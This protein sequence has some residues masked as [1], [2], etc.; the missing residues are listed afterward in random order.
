ML[1][2]RTHYLAYHLL[3]QTEAVLKYQFLKEK[4]F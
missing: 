4:Y 1:K 2:H 3:N